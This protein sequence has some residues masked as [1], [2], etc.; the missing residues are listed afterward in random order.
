MDIVNEQTIWFPDDQL[1]SSRMGNGYSLPIEFVPL[2]KLIELVQKR[3]KEDGEWIIANGL[4]GEDNENEAKMLRMMAFAANEKNIGQCYEHIL[5]EGK[6]KDLT[7]DWVC[8]E[9]ANASR[10]MI[11]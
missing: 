11:R 4:V 3:V 6:E 8:R 7:V 2:A 5:A 10:F 1:Y 9:L